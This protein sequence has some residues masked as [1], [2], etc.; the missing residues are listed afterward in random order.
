MPSPSRQRTRL[1]FVAALLAAG[2][3]GA[4]AATPPIVIPLPSQHIKLSDLWSSISSASGSATSVIPPL[5]DVLPQLGQLTGITYFP[6][7]PLAAGLPVSV[8][9]QVKNAPIAAAT[10][11][12]TATN[13]YAIPIELK[14]FLAGTD[15]YQND[16]TPAV[17]NMGPAGSA[18]ST[19]TATHSVDP[20][21]LSAGTLAVGFGLSSA[22]SGG[23]SVTFD[24]SSTVDIESSIAVSFKLTAL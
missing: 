13:N 14:I 5:P 22:G 8:P 4:C 1:P 20:A 7:P 10:L 12:L 3:M 11:N 19:A 9:S 21:A 17:L 18:T 23:Q 15:P 24:P 2:A 6:V 16:S